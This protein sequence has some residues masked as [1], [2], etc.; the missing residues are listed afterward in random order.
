MFVNWVST[1]VC[2]PLPRG[3]GSRMADWGVYNIEWKLNIDNWLSKDN[4]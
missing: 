1:Y 2:A 4:I 3:A